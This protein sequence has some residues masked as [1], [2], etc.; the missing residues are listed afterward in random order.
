MC[1]HFP[2]RLWDSE[3]A[4][5]LNQWIGIRFWRSLDGNGKPFSS[6]PA[7][8]LIIRQPCREELLTA[9]HG[10]CRLSWCWFFP[11]FPEQKTVPSDI[12]DDLIRWSNRYRHGFLPPYRLFRYKY[13]STDTPGAVLFF[14]YW[15]RHFGQCGDRYG[16]IFRH[17]MFH[18]MPDFCG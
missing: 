18:L 7:L 17:R 13:I 5:G 14:L 1:R 12:F 9:M 10:M 16:R 8:I 15:I 3:Q 2:E 4:S 11:V 6:F